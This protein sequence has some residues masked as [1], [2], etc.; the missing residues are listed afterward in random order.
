MVIQFNS[1][2]TFV[3]LLISW[4]TSNHESDEAPSPAS[5]ITAQTHKAHTHY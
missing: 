1:D 2:T 4:Y 3:N 5:N